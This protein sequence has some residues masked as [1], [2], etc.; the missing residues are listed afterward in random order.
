MMANFV[1]RTNYFKGIL[2]SFTSGDYHFNQTFAVCVL[3]SRNPY[4]LC[5]ITGIK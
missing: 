4:F 1:F 5:G 3:I 2:S